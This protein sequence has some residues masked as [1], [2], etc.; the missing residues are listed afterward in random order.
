M[1]FEDIRRSYGENE[2]LVFSSRKDS[3]W[4]CYLFGST[5]DNPGITYTPAVGNVPNWFVRWMMKLCLA[6]TWVKKEER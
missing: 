6:C 2:Q 1:S 3:D 4:E 5:P